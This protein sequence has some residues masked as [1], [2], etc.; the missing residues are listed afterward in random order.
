MS[1]KFQQF[2]C[3]RVSQEKGEQPIGS[4]RQVPAFVLIEW[5]R[6]W[7]SSALNTE[8]LPDEI[9]ESYTRA[10]REN[11][12]AGKCLLFDRDPEYSTDQFRVFYY[13]LPSPPHATYEKEEYIL[14]KSKLSDLCSVLL[15]DSEERSDFSEFLRPEANEREIFVC[16]HRERDP[17]CGKYGAEAYMNLRNEYASDDRRIWKISH[18]GGHRFAP[19]IIDLPHG[20]YWG[21]LQT[22]EL[23]SFVHRNEDFETIADR[24]RGWCALSAPEQV[25]EQA[26]L[27]EEGWS[28]MEL[29]KESKML[30]TDSDSDEFEIEFNCP[31]GEREAY[32]KTVRKTE[33]IERLG[34]PC[35]EVYK[36]PRYKTAEQYEVI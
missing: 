34:T 30:Q 29:R 28:W 9:Q 31:N 20:R 10:R 14:P 24:Y 33:S 5:P 2:E 13:H 8:S 1:N 17:C 6:P 25:A 19:N 4:A 35:G 22:E 18:I 32:R 11:E 21:R 7:G 27:V 3:S 36:K 26:I 12:F 23:D 16:N 15:E